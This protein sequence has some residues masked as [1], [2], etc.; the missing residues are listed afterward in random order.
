[1]N[2]VESTFGSFLKVKFTNSL[3]FG[4]NVAPYVFTKILKPAMSYS[5][6]RGYRS[7]IYLDDILCIGDSEMSCR[8]NV[9]ATVK[10]L[11]SLRFLLQKRKCDLVPSVKKEYLGLLYDSSQMAITLPDSKKE[12]VFE[13][14]TKFSQLSQCKIKQFASFVG[15]IESCCRA[16]QYGRIHTKDFEREKFLA[17]L[18][19]DNNYDANMSIKK[20][21]QPS[22]DWWKANIWTLSKPIGTESYDHVLFTDSSLTGWGAFCENKRTNG[23]W[24]AY[25]RKLH[26]NYLELKAAFLALKCFAKNWSNCKLLLRIDNTT[27]LAYVNKMG[28]IQYPGLNKI[29]REI[30]EFCETKKI[31]LFASYIKSKDNVEADRGSR[32]KNIDTEWELADHAF[33]AAVDQFGMPKIDLFA[34]R[35]NKKC[36]K[37]FS[38]KNDPEVLAIDA[39]TC[40]WGNLGKFWAFPPFALITKTI[41]KI[42]TDQATGILVVPNW[43]NQPWFP[44]FNAYLV[45]KPIVF[46]PS[47]NLLLSPC[48]SIQNH[49]A[50]NLSLVVGVLS[51]AQSVGKECLK[52]R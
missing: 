7:V 45:S 27:A 15:L 26:I 20:S 12:K 29:A 48:R 9:N 18:I 42:I 43:P 35:I 5:R 49:L 8:D 23:F 32:V 2:Q 37:Y 30:W 4:L 6:L 19:N 1:M 52:T 21:L 31:W 46:K 22:F 41:R 14:V 25:E 33:Q 47:S 50:R 39:F 24:S 28:G 40:D 34:S 13:T 44:L 11:K 51:G 17:L 38:W 36:P 10:L 3:A 16:S